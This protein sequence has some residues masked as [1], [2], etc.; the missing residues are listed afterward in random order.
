MSKLK[1]SDKTVDVL[2]YTGLAVFLIGGSTL[3][4]LRMRK[5]NKVKKDTELA[6]QNK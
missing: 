3:V 4:Y 1:L 5:L 2:V 6:L